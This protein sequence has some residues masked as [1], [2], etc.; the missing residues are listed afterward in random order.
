LRGAA[1]ALVGLMMDED[2]ATLK[3]CWDALAAVSASV[4]KEVQPSYVRCVKEAV[5][6]AREKERRKRRAGALLLP[7]FCLPKALAP[8]LPFY[9][10]GVL[11]ARPPAPPATLAHAAAAL[12]GGNHAGARCE[13]AAE[14]DVT[15]PGVVRG[16]AGARGRGPGRDGG[17]DQRGGAAAVRG[18]DHRR[19][20]PAGHRI[21]LRPVLRGS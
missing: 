2:A 4:P 16:A 15:P 17:G 11:Q 21:R 5:G 6:T 1:Q 20:G 13:C 7:G 14:A 18:P 3:A 10:Q 8:L 19:A 9:L 12:P